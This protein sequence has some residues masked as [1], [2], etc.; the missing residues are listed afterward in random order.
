MKLATKIMLL[1]ML[2]VAAITGLFSYLTI[3][4]DTLFFA[5]DHERHAKN[6][7]ETM[8]P[9]L[10]SAWQD[11]GHEEVARVVKASSKM[12]RHIRVRY[13][14]LDV[15][16]EVSPGTNSSL[17]S[18]SADPPEVLALVRQQEIVTKL[19]SDESGEN[20]VHT[21]LPLNLGD[22]TS[23]GIEVSGTMQPVDERARKTITRSILSVLAMALICGGMLMIGG[24]RMLGRPLEKLVEKTKRAG[25]GDFSEPLQLNQSD[26]LG[27]LATALN[28]MCGQLDQQREAIHS[29]T[30]ARLATQEQL[31]HADRLKTVGRLASGIAHEMGTPLNVVSGRA[32]LIASGK[33]SGDEVH[34]SAIVIK[35]ETD[36]ITKIIRELLDFSRRSTPQRTLVDLGDVVSQA[37]DLLRNFAEKRSVQITMESSG[38]SFQSQIDAGQIQQVITNLVMNAIQS[39]AENQEAGHVKVHI[40]SINASPPVDIELVPSDYFQIKIS[41]NG[42]GIPSDRLHEIFEP[43]FT[44][45]DIGEGTGLGLSIS[46]GIVREHAG[47][48]DVT[49]EVGRGSCFSVYLP[50]HAQPEGKV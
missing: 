27:Q 30:T 47:W 23:G 34:Q 48:I 31:R 1:F 36:R 12:I 50:V 6:L 37:I 2:A 13:V 46:Y 45:K 19:V 21:T 39:M 3:R 41:D 7:V 5:Q 33:L 42:S 29:E 38:D 22:Q 32:G 4:Q 49:S 17:E 44:T 40:T 15:Q 43:F 10:L 9:R 18:S 11:G 24:V 14:E 26:E 16:Y 8:R 25:R 20:R 28:E 35:G